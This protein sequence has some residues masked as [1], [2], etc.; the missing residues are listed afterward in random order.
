MTGSVAALTKG[1]TLH[2]IT[3]FEGSKRK[4]TDSDR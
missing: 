3:H 2:S 1:V 4:N